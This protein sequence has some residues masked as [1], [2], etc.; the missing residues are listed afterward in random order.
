MKV[1][2]LACIDYICG[3]FKNILKSEYSNI[4]ARR[5]EPTYVH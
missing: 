1:T 5:L 4:V 2:L 3:S